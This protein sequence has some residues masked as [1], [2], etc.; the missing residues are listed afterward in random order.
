MNFPLLITY[1]RR[2]IEKILG[3]WG[4]GDLLTYLQDK[5]IMFI[6]TKDSSHYFRGNMKLNSPSC[7]HMGKVRAIKVFSTIYFTWGNK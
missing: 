5:N 6:Y 1:W 7:K 3:I 2:S 4:E